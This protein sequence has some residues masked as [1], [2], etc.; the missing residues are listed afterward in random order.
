[1]KFFLFMP[2]GVSS[3]GENEESVSNVSLRSEDI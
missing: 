1:M 2:A 3:S